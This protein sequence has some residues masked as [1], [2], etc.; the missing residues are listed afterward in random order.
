MGL[1]RDGGAQRAD[2]G[3]GHGVIMGGGG[4]G[5]RA[6]LAGRV[7][8]RLVVVVV[9]LLGRVALR[10]QAEVGPQLWERTGY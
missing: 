5:R 1:V 4:G 2:P 6:A 7:P 8:A 9:V 10:G 3:R